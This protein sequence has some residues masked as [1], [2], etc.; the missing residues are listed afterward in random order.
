MRWL[1]ALAFLSFTS[2]YPACSGAEFTSSEQGGSAG[3]AGTAGTAG[4]AGRGGGGGSSGRDAS[5]DVESDANG[6]RDGSAGADS[7]D[8]SNDASV[9]S[10]SD[11]RPD[12][13]ADAPADVAPTCDAPLA[14]FF[15]DDEDGYGDDTTRVSACRS[16]GEDWVLVGGDCDDDLP[17]VHP[18]QTD[19]FGEG[20]ETKQGISFDYDCSGLED[21]DP[22][23]PR[24]AP[25]TCPLAQPCGSPGYVPAAR[26]GPGVDPI[27]GS[28]LIQGCAPNLGLCSMQSPVMA[29][30]KR[31][32]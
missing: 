1:G 31:C 25:T 27:C 4:S 28:Q 29:T 30:A 7:G 26:S 2:V 32:R 15:D 12:T 13:A 24:R 10:P 8:G 17:E 16:P 14:Y 9:D 5:P 20:Y 21:P 23:Q 18:D 3:R 22:V 19:F 11:A 6:G